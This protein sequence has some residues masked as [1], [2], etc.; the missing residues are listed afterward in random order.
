MHMQGTPRTMQKHPHYDDLM[1]DILATLRESM[2]R[3]TEAGVRESQLLVDPGIGFGKTVEHNL[4]ILRCLPELRSLGRP[5]LL[6]TSRKSFIGKILDL[7]VDQRLL[8]TAATVAYGIAQGAHIVRVH[9]VAE[10]AQVA[11]MTDAMLGRSEVGS[12]KSEGEG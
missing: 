4:A 1:G 9:D 11:R 8:G 5:I 2:A 6:G 3:A 7:P 12:T 10:M